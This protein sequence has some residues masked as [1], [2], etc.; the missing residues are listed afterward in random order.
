M[1][2]TRFD[3][4]EIEEFSEVVSQLLR[5]NGYVLVDKSEAYLCRPPKQNESR[6][7]LSFRKE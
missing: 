4:E 1:D 3:N 2:F 7:Y 6:V 5:Q